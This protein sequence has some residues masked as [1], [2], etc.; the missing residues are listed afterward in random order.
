MS[1]DYDLFVLD[2]D[3]SVWF[4]TANTLEDAVNLIHRHA[5]EE[6]GKFLVYSQRNGTKLLYNATPYGVYLQPGSSTTV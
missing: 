5:I 3:K 1:P 6:P 4:G 2:H